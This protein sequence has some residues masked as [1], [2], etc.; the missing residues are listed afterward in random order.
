MQPLPNNFVAYM[1]IT[2]W[3]IFLM[4]DL[5]SVKEAMGMGEEMY[6]EDQRCRCL[7]FYPIILICL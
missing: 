7:W 2:D 5:A 4:K 6:E 3:R 1:E